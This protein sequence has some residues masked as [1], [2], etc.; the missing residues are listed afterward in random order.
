MGGDFNFGQLPEKP[1]WQEIDFVNMSLPAF[2]TAS[3]Y[4]HSVNQDFC[5]K[6]PRVI[7]GS[8]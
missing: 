4:D 1:P 3:A 2:H 5:M 8:S 6:Y 7:L